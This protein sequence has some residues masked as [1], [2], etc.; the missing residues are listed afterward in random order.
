MS[1][2]TREVSLNN[3]TV[4]FATSTGS[5]PNSLA[6]FGAYKFGELLR[7]AWSSFP[8]LRVTPA[9]LDPK[10]PDVYQ[11]QKRTEGSG[12]QAQ[13]EYLTALIGDFSADC[14]LIFPTNKGTAFI[15]GCFDY[16]TSFIGKMGASGQMVWKNSMNN[17]PVRLRNGYVTS[18]GGL[19][20][21]G[22]DSDVPGTALV[23]QVSGEGNVVWATDIG[24]FDPEAS[25]YIVQA[26]PNPDGGSL[27]LGVLNRNSH[28]GQGHILSEVNATGH[29]SSTRSISAPNRTLTGYRM[30]VA[31]SG[32]T[33]VA[34]HVTGFGDDYQTFVYKLG[35]H[36]KVV[37]KGVF[38]GFVGTSG[39]SFDPI[40]GAI[41][42]DHEGHVVIAGTHANRFLVQTINSTDGSLISAVS[43][44]GDNDSYVLSTAYPLDDGS[45]ILIGSLGKQELS[46]ACIMKLDS[47]RNLLWARGIISGNYVTGHDGAP[48]SDGD[49]FFVG[50]ANGGENLGMLVAK[51]DANGE[52]AGRCDLV[53]TIHPTSEAVSPAVLS[54]LTLIT[55]PVYAPSQ[56][57]NLSLGAADINQTTTCSY[58]PSSDLPWIVLGT[59]GSLVFVFVTVTATVYCYRQRQGYEPVN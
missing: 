44:G 51:L 34:G 35:A 9:P 48:S 3:G 49:L 58:T 54:N 8:S 12:P 23:L 29:L 25:S 13:T 1:G 28:S 46:K 6:G 42:E 18:D 43:I 5:A 7:W 24:S 47:E 59:V 56:P 55:Q 33:V 40:G 30:I 15:I 19:L 27:I 11:K 4:G 37:W 16:Q 10:T 53:E 20:C 2:S 22:T 41:F 39:R 38:Q 14:P 26:H 17:S 36:G 50:S 45:M 52:I 21:V 31:G 32:E 57:V